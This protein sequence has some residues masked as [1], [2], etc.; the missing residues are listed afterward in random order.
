MSQQFKTKRANVHA[1]PGDFEHFFCVLH[2][3]KRQARRPAHAISSEPVARWI[4]ADAAACPASPW[5][6]LHVPNPPHAQRPARRFSQRPQGRQTPYRPP[7][8][9][10]SPAHR[11]A[12]VPPLP[13]GLNHAADGTRRCSAVRLRGSS[14]PRFATLC[15]SCSSCAVSNFAI[16]AA[17]SGGGVCPVFAWCMVSFKVGE[18]M[19][20]GGLFMALAPVP[21]PIR[22]FRSHPFPSVL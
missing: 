19:Q 3:R 4:H 2:V 16:A 22:S 5:S 17:S 21:H 20:S 14:A 12:G 18:G 9:G 8:D 13:G 6:A 1:N 7:A 10:H 11:R 15:A